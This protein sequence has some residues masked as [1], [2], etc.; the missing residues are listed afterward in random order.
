AGEDAFEY[1]FTRTDEEWLAE[2]GDFD[3]AIL[4]EGETEQQFTNPYWQL[5]EVGKFH[6]KGCDLLAY[7]SERKFFPDKG[8]AFFTAGEPN[9]HMFSVDTRGTMSDEMVDETPKR[10]EIAANFFMEVHCRRCGSHHGHIV[11]ID[12]RPLHCINGGSLVFKPA[13]A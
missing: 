8:W 9:A 13:N 10:N 1:E 6:C 12:S 5:N 2:L 3:F 7:D 4:R 11:S